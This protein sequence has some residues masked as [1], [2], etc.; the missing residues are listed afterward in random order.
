[1]KQNIMETVKFRTIQ[2]DDNPALAKIVRDT[3][4]EFGANH[5]GTVYYDPTTDHLF[6]MFQH[7]LSVYLVAEMEGE[8]VGGGGIYPTDGLPDKTC[9]LVKMYLLP[10]ARGKGVG[11]MIIA[12]CVEKAARLGF[13][14]VYL[15]TMPELQQAM[16]VYEKFGFRYL[17]GPLGN[18]GHFGCSK[19]ML[20]KL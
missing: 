8:L 18:S 12:D 5:P 20:K 15:E 13:E 11:K 17:N 14:N 4:A 9:E 7:P 2:P 1:V 10:V 19:W 6:E 16:Q 3:L